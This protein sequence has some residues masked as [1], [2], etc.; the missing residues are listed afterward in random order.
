MGKVCRGCKMKK[1]TMLLM[2][3]LMAVLYGCGSG[4]GSG[5]AV[6]Q[7]ANMTAIDFDNDATLKGTYKIVYASVTCTN[8]VD[9]KSTDILTTEFTS[10]YAYDGYYSYYDLYFEYGGQLVLDE[11]ERVTET[12][13][14]DVYATTVTQT[15]PYNFRVN[16]NNVP[17]GSG[18]TCAERFDFMKISD[19]LK[20]QYFRVL[21]GSAVVDMSKEA[22]KGFSLYKPTF[23][24]LIK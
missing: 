24:N 10:Y 8:G 13:G 2:V 16:Y 7:D 1:Y 21:D 19:S 22:K 14:A 18:V 20:S 9:V 6:E 11:G 15:S 12:V 23:K 17:V 5:D 4:G 3:C